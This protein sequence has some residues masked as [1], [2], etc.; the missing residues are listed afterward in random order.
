MFIERDYFCQILLAS[1]NRKHQIFFSWNVLVSKKIYLTFLYIAQ[2]FMAH[3]PMALTFSLWKITKFFLVKYLFYCKYLH[4]KRLNKIN[5][6]SVQFLLKI[7][8]LTLNYRKF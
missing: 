4:F 6:E 2:K 5:I 8:I 3:F 7:D 1:F